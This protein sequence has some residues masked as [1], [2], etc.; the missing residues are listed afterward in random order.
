MLHAI[1]MKSISWSNWY[2]NNLQLPS[3]QGILSK[4]C[5]QLWGRLKYEAW[6]ISLGFVLFYVKHEHVIGMVWS[7]LVGKASYANHRVATFF[8][9]TNRLMV[10]KSTGK[11][12]DGI[13]S[14]MV[15]KEWGGNCILTLG[16]CVSRWLSRMHTEFD[17]SKESLDLPPT[18]RMC[19]SEMA[20]NEWRCLPESLNLIHSRSFILSRNRSLPSQ[21]AWTTTL[22]PR[23]AIP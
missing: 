22:L 23:T 7:R 1:F 3:T 12:E 9:Y 21:P 17:S 8:G 18:S 15:R 4:E 6:W 13:G 19:L 10:P 16:S 5:L 14:I 2:F 20:V 11:C